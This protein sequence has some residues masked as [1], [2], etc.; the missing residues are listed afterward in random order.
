[1]KSDRLQPPP[2]EPPVFAEPREF[3]VHGVRLRDDYAWLKAENWMEVLKDPAVLPPRIRAHL[4]A[5]NAYTRGG[6][7]RHGAAARAT[8][9][10]D[11]R[12][13]QGGRL[14]PC[15]KPTAPSPTSPA[16]A[17]AASTR[18]SAASRATAA[19]SEILLD[20]DA[21][22]EGRRLLRSRTTPTIRPTTGFSPG[23][24]TRRAPSSSRS[25]S[26][27][28]R[29]ARISPTRCSR[30]PARSSGRAIR[31]AFY[32]VEV[33]EKHRPV[34]V[35]APPPRHAGGGGRARLRGDRA[36][37]LH[38][39][40][41]STQSGA[42]VVI[43]GRAITRPRRSGSSTARTRA[44]RPA[45]SPR[46]TPRRALSRRAPRRRPR[47]PAPT[48]TAPRTSRSSTA[49][50][51]APGARELARSRPAPAG[52]HDPLPHGARPPSRAA[53]ARGREAA[54]R[55]A[56]HLRPARSTRSPST[57]RPIRS[58][59]DPGY[60]FDTDIIRF[61]YSSLT[62]PTEVYDYD[63]R[64]ARA[65][66]CASA[67]R[68][69]AATI[70]PPTSRAASSRR[71][72]DGEQVPIS[73]VHRRELALDGSAPVPPLRLRLLR[74]LDAGR[75]SA[76]TRSRS[77]TAAS[78]TPSPMSAA[79]PRRAGAGT[80]R[81]AREQAE[82]LHRLHRLRRGARSRRATRRA[83]ASSPTAAAP[84]AC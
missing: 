63:M 66:A 32:Y 74:L 69:R 48:P 56:R 52:R 42:F 1:M 59:V 55:R 83:G 10:R 15:R 62:T 4:E 3:E 77:S 70:R 11:A 58:A 34:R 26:A 71:R 41:T 2:S 40:S 35:Q 29:P 53:R 49:P 8:R 60:E 57:R 20:G 6:A 28:S 19:P 21:G 75:A 65:R 12:A 16:T 82:H 68:C 84:A 30:P 17:R 25:G 80:R 81:Q 61:S 27:T 54:H 43:D 39:S 73:L 22:G 14:A 46:A 23:A 50:L 38:R 18:S 36:R 76:P 51:A 78:S 45:S 13:H 31:R 47:H 5:E 9:R 24:P 67:R 64:T 7:R 33:D 79:A 72:R 37:L 44:P